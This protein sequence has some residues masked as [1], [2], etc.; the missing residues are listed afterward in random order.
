MAQHQ[1]QVDGLWTMVRET[2]EMS[3]KSGVDSG[4]SHT[5]SN[6][7]V[8]RRTALMCFGA[9]NRRRMPDEASR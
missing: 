8:W 5:M 7:N 1:L 9:E 3:V 6:T 2:N 4:L